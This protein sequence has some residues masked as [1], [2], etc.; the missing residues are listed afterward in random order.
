M[1]HETNEIDMS[2]A[3]RAKVANDANADV[4]LRIHAN[5]SEDPDVNGMM[6]IC[7]TPENPY[8]PQIYE[9]SYALSNNVLDCMVEATGAHKEYV[10][11]TETMSGI[12]WCE[13]PVTIIEMGYMTNEI[14]DLAMQTTEYQ[15]QL[16]DGI[17]NGVDLYLSEKMSRNE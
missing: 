10:W 3:E 9:D 15:L 11:E 7:P 2:N 14:E 1:I 8:C 13:V 12:N 6:T 16:V 5:G 17:C 4:F